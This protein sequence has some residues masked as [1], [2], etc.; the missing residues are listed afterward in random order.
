[1]PRLFAFLRAINV[2][3]HT[4]TMARLA[5]VFDELGF[6]HAETFIASGNV[7][8]QSR[9]AASPALE[10]KL[11]GGLEAALGFP[12]ATFLRTEPELATL[13][14]PPPFGAREEA[15]AHALMVGFLHAA[16]AAGAAGRV[17]ALR[18]ATDDV[19]L[20]GRELWWLRRERESATAL[21]NGSF[22]RA[23]GVPATFRNITTVRRLAGKYGL[24]RG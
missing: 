13:A 4:V 11:A 1:M 19:Q 8:F 14:G 15:K 9:A 10:R 7:I 20:R 12:V 2:G 6:P 18:S 23:L 3:G 16:P 24:M 5:A 17:V 22:E 21:V